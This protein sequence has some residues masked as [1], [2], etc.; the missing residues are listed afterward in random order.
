M[1]PD[2]C[3]LYENPCSKYWSVFPKKMFPV[4]CFLCENPWSSWLLDVLCIMFSVRLYL[5]QMTVRCSLYHVPFM[6][7][8]QFTVRCSLQ[9]KP[10]SKWLF[11]VPCSM[12]PIR[13]SRC[14]RTV[15][16][17]SW[18]VRR[19]VA[20]VRTSF[21]SQRTRSGVFATSLVLQQQ[22]PQHPLLR[23]NSRTKIMC[24]TASDFSSTHREVG[25]LQHQPCHNSNTYNSNTDDRNKR[26]RSLWNIA[27][28]TAT[29]MIERCE[30]AFKHLR[31]QQ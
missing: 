26:I 25:H 1:P 6:S 29:S 11:R 8:F 27:T 7:L 20:S 13:Q 5:W 22:Q 18:R 24:Y 17:Q 31:Q 14:S 12:F 10:C 2:P 15:R 30:I 28:S 9:D 19:E 23:D 3:S 21:P 16:R 4:S